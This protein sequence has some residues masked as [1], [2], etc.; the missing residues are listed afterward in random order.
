[1]CTPQWFCGS[2]A[3]S[4]RAQAVSVWS[5]SRTGF[6]G[7]AK[8]MSGHSRE[9]LQN[10]PRSCR[11]LAT[12]VRPYAKAFQNRL[13]AANPWDQI[14]H[15]S[16]LKGLKEPPAARPHTSAILKCLR[17]TGPTRIIAWG[18]AFG[19][20]RYGCPLRWTQRRDSDPGN[21]RVDLR[22]TY[23][24]PFASA[25]CLGRRFAAPG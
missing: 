1:M 8:R 6:C 15:R 11:A 21:R 10:T 13:F 24:A 16:Y 9:A 2:R 7:F 18:G 17:A 20:P 3:T 14:P 12:C 22:R 19:G 5:G 23:S 4:S 25:C